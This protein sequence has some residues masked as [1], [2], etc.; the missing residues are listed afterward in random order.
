MNHF[1]K[2]NKIQIKKFRKFDDIVVE[3]KNG[4]YFVISGK[5]GTGKTS[6]LEAIN[7]AFSERSS[8]F[9]EVKETDFYSDD[10]IEFIIELEE[11]FFLSFD[12]GSGYERLIPCKKFKKIIE[13]RGR[14]ESGKTF[15]SCYD[16]SWKFLPDNFNI[17][18]RKFQQLENNFNDVLGKRQKIVETF[19][20]IKDTKFQYAIKTKPGESI[21][22]EHIGFQY[23]KRILFPEIFYYDNNREREL[24][25]AYNTTTTNII[26]EIEWRYKK[27]FIKNKDDLLK[28]YEDLQ[29][30][31]YS[32]DNY[33]DKLLEPAKKIIRDD[34]KIQEIDE[35]L[36]N[37]FCL[38]CYQPY[39]NS[40][41][42]LQSTKGQIIPA[43][44][45]G[46][47]I[48]SLLALSMSISFAQNSNVPIIILIDEPEIH[49]QSTLQKN[50]FMF[51]SKNKSF[52]SIIA[53]HSHLFLEKVE[54]G[55]NIIL[56]EDENDMLVK[57]CEK[58]DLC[59]LQFRLLGNSIDDL[60]VPEKILLV[61]GKHD[62]N[63]IFKCL[64]LMN[65][66]FLQIQII[67]VGGKDNMP[68]KSEQYEVVINEI[69]KKGKWY[70]DY[71]IKVLKIV[72][73]NDVTSEKINDWVNKYGFQ[74]DDQIKKVDFNG[75]EYL[76]PESLIKEGIENSKLKDGTFLKD[77]S[78]AEII[79][80]ILE[81]DK[82]N[83]D[84][85]DYNQIE[86]RVSKSRLNLFV[87]QNITKDIL[88]SDESLELLNL[89]K[90]I[91]EVE[92]KLD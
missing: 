19:I 58:I 63:I 39:S 33:K 10:P 24:L 61:E 44:N 70:S 79:N 21:T 74:Q 57:Y 86:N 85:T 18:R 32:L 71:I 87:L 49:L 43:L 84:A 13:R 53:T 15:S 42:G 38:N 6:I 5:N 73:D 46:S 80:I 90:W 54:Y 28:K 36:I 68:D 41:F 92:R 69:L 26:N 20:N 37:F 16:I 17:E 23:M 31:I 50:L 9:T 25:T 48:A 2:I 22:H 77:K 88:Q 67:P 89:V 56:E 75:I 52:Q 51:L 72:V 35:Q 66:K 8:K 40:T 60:L 59:D 91:I 4:N 82:K 64:E 78:K 81:D 47:G 62:K 11:Y 65:K 45:M 14:K 3:F 12:D 30:S 76:F 1:N 27:Q 7:L 34:L 55:N 29:N 83:K